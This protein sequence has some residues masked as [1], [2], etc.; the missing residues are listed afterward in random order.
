MILLASKEKKNKRSILISD[1]SN[2]AIADVVVNTM[3]LLPLLLAYKREDKMKPETFATFLVGVL[4]GTIL[5]I[6][7]M[8]WTRPEE[9]NL[10][11]KQA[12]MTPYETRPWV[13]E[14]AL[15]AMADRNFLVCSPNGKL[16]ELK[17][18]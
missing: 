3:I 8:H 9:P 15:P 12:R 11:C 14:G 16:Y 18:N 6:L 4:V 7:V 13:P 2:N 17:E 5:T 1:Q 10:T